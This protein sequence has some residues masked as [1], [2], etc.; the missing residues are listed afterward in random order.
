MGLNICISLQDLHERLVTLLLVFRKPR[1]K[2]TNYAHSSKKAN[3]EITLSHVFPQG[4]AVIFWISV[5]ISHLKALAK[6]KPK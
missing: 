5:I 2:R 6:I 1:V 4:C 3:V